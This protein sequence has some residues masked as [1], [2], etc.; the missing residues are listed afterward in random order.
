MKKP[1]KLVKG[2]RIAIVSPSWGGPSVAP[3]I[4][5][6]GLKN[7]ESLGFIPVEF[8][9][10]RMEAGEL[11]HHPEVRARDINDAFADESIKGIISSIGGS[12]S[13]RILKYL[14]R[15]VIRHNPKFLMGYSD[16]TTLNAW[17]NQLGLV[18]FNGPAVMAGLSQ[19]HSFPRDYQNYLRDYLLSPIKESELPVFSAYSDG[20]PEWADRRNTG[21]LNTLQKSEGL[22]FL[23]GEKKRQ[24]SSFR[25]LHRGPGNAQGNRLLA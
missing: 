17:L 18:T 15:D 24:G 20:Y 21:K 2:D 11:Y 7:L 4:F 19:L 10:T 8:P 5:D 16:F 9:T 12:D 25:R 6:S 22:H 3:H 23:Q 1:P 14:D 13:V